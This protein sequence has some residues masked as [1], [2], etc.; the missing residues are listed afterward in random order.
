MLRILDVRRTDSGQP[1]SFQEMSEIRERVVTS[2]R[3]YMYSGIF[4]HPTGTLAASI[5]AFVRDQSI[6]I[7]SELPYAD[8]QD[9][10][11]A[12]HI[13][14]YLLGKTIPIRLYG[15]GG[16][17]VIYRKATMQ[18]FLE[19]KWF[20]P[21][22]TPKE[23]IKTGMDRALLQMDGIDASIRPGSAGYALF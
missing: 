8:A 17:R 2:I 11:I 1:V 9:K 21:G 16:S 4:K 19:G 10:G 14:W 3:E 18:S 15:F 13:Q 23:F 6:Y 7:V 22:V 20:H 5:N 12:P